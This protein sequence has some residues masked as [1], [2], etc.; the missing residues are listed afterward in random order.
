MIIAIPDKTRKSLI[1]H[2]GV[3]EREVAALRKRLQNLALGELD[4]EWK[5]LAREIAKRK[6]QIRALDVETT[7]DAAQRMFPDL[8]D[9]GGADGARA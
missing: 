2:V 4:E 6:E 3:L 7:D 9:K 8:R 5:I 1:Q